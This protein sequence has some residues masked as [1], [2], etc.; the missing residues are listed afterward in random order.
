MYYVSCYWR[1]CTREGN[2]AWVRLQCLNAR[3]DRWFVK[4]SM[5]YA[6]K[7]IFYIYMFFLYNIRLAQR[8][9]EYMYLWRLGAVYLSK[10]APTL[11]FRSR[12]I[13]LIHTCTR[14]FLCIKNRYVA[15]NWLYFVKLFHGRRLGGDYGVSSPKPVK[16]K[17]YQRHL[18]AITPRALID[19]RLS[20]RSI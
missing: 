9:Y 10:N 11:F 6:Q 13:A 4:F 5:M 17:V 2:L 15:A 16:P 14:I 19:M 20:K 12:F 7:R 3:G 1:W 8:N 18:P